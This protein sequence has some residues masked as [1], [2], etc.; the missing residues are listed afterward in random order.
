M[1]P[2]IILPINGLVAWEETEQNRD[3][4]GKELFMKIEVCLLKGSKRTA[5]KLEELH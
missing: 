3:A 2:S 4:V 5:Q 1:S